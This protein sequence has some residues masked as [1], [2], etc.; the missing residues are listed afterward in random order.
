MGYI[1][2]AL[3]IF[4]CLVLAFT[5]GYVLAKVEEAMKHGK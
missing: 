3:T 2:I 5:A 1:E 4:G